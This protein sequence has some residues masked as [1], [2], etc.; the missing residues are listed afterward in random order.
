MRSPIQP[1]LTCCSQNKLWFL[2]VHIS[3]HPSDILYFVTIQRSGSLKFDI[4]FQIFFRGQS[5]VQPYVKSEDELLLSCGITHTGTTQIISV[6]FNLGGLQL[7][8]F[9]F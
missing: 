2:V 4:F 5:T 7:Q 9:H 1:V 6:Y 8:Q 3:T